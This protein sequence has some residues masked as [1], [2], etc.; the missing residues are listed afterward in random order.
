[1]LF[2]FLSVAFFALLPVASASVVDRRNAKPAAVVEAQPLITARAPTPARYEATKTLKKR[3]VIS[4]LA[5]D[6]SSIL[7]SLGSDIPSYVASGVANF[8]QGAFLCLPHH[9][10]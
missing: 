8:F 4:D 9:C 7:G 1:M 5:G 10:Y 2:H 3:G 6:V